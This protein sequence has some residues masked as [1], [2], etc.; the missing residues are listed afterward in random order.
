MARVGLKELIIYSCT[1]KQKKT[2]RSFT[3][4]IDQI[5]KNIRPNC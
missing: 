4:Q 1:M 2:T 3:N 5:I